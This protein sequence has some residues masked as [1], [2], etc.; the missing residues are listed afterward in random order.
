M[1]N[2]NR[3]AGFV[4]RPIVLVASG[5]E[6]GLIL[7]L[8][9]RAGALEAD[10]SRHESWEALWLPGLFILPS[11]SAFVMALLRRALGAAL[12]LCLL[13]ALLAAFALLIARTATVAG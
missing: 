7:W 6:L 2:A 11:G 1:R 5:L 10:W 12:L 8:V 13:Y 9:L 3:P 4:L